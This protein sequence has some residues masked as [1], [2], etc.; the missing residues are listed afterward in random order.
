MVKEGNDGDDQSQTERPV[1]R[2]RRRCDGGGLERAS[3]RRFR[4]GRSRCAAAAGRRTSRSATARTRGSA[5]QPRKRRSRDAD[6]IKPSAIM[7]D[8]IYRAPTSVA[9]RCRRRVDLLD[10]RDVGQRVGVE[11]DEV[12]PLAGFERPEVRVD[13]PA[14]R[15]VARR[16]LQHLLRRQAGLHHQLQLHQLEVALE[17][18][19]RAGVGAHRDRARRRRTSFLRFRLATSSAAL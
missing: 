2:R 5:S 9:R 13:L 11:H 14:A 16:R 17:P 3:L 4:S 15:G 6:T 18:A 12:G 7:P 19:G 10:V 8:S 1:S